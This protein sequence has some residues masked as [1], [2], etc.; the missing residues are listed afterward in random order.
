MRFCCENVMISIEFHEINESNSQNSS[1]FNEQMRTSKCDEHSIASNRIRLRQQVTKLTISKCDD[2][3]TTTK[4][5][6]FFQPIFL[7]FSSKNP[8]FRIIGEKIDLFDGFECTKSDHYYLFY[9]L[10]D[11]N[12]QN[13]RTNGVFNSVF[14]PQFFIYKTKMGRIK[15]FHGWHQKSVISYHFVSNTKMYFFLN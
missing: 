15:F 1:K 10:N 14:S 4:A 6:E 5:T 2:V 11:L 13:I 12:L 8:Q 9:T 7:I 3:F